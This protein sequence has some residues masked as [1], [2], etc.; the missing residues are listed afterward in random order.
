MYEEATGPQ[1]YGCD[2][3]LL[4]WCRSRVSKFCIEKH[5]NI[6]INITINI[7]FQTLTLTP[8]LTLI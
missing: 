3:W 6:N 7:N 1:E 4:K 5:D 2:A 8:T